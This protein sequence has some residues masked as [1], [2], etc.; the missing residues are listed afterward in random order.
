MIC[1]I[2]E[3]IFSN[4]PSYINVETALERIRTGKSK[5]RIDE[6]RNTIDKEKADLLK[7]NLP[8]VCFSGK[9]TERLDD[10]LVD[11]SGFIVLDFDEVDDIEIK[12]YELSLIEFVYALWLSPRGNGLKVLVKIADDTKHREHFES[13][14][15]YFGLKLDRDGN[16]Q[17]DKKNR[18]IYHVDR[19]GVNVSRVCYESYDPNIFINKDAKVY[20]GIIEVETVNETIK[21][22]NENEIFKNVITW[23]TNKGD[24]FVTGERNLYIFKLASACCRFGILQEIAERLILSEYQTSNTFTKKECETTIKSAYRANTTLFNSAVFDKGVLVDKVTRSQ[25]AID[26]DVYNKEIKPRDVIYSIDVKGHALDIFENGYESVM[27]IGVPDLD[28]LFKMK[29]GEITLLTGIGNY[30]K[31]QFKKWY[32]VFRAV[33]FGERFASFPPEDYPVH[34]YYHEL[35]E[36]LLGANCTPENKNRPSRAEYNAAYDFIGQHFFYIYPTDL[37]PTPDY[38]KQRFLELVIKENIDGCDI[39]PFN[40]MTNDY[41]KHGGRDD[42][43]LET[44]LAD[45]LR[46]AQQNDKYFWIV[47]HPHKLQKQQD[48]NYPCPDVYDLAGGAMWNNKMNNILVYHRPTMQTEPTSPI[49]ELHTKKIKDQKTVG[50]RGDVQFKYI[51]STRRFEFNNVDY[52]EMALERK[53]LYFGLKERTAIKF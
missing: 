48:G 32:Q 39:D 30:G 19:S 50:S 44:T 14:K 33:V 27:P 41:S 26:E 53:K 6:I 47:A 46:F 24:A 7:R 28:A 17:Y 13:L 2:F 12:A 36:I 4:E 10:K 42:K 34:N 25:I 31:S 38:I 45:F 35:T 29:R 8:C 40:Q 49:C 9:F 21:L 20:A 18:P 37:A 51:R 43:Y 11:H 16:T 22:A 52:L 1:T 5:K 23:L 3:N 15:E